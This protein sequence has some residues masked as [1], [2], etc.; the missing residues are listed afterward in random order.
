METHSSPTAARKL[1]TALRVVRA[2]AVAIAVV[3]VTGSLA[4]ACPGCAEALEGTDVGLGINTS[5]LFLIAT[6][7]LVIAGSGLAV[8]HL[9]R[10]PRPA[11]FAAAADPEE[12]SP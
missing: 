4:R 2:L 7:M 6:P 12:T 3:A 1:R 8:A 10:T 5:I 9:M 11:A